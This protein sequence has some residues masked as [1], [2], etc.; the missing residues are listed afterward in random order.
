VPPLILTQF[1]L[2]VGFGAHKRHSAYFLAPLRAV[3]IH[4][5]LNREFLWMRCH[6][7]RMHSSTQVTLSPVIFSPGHFVSQSLCPQSLCPQVTF[8]PNQ[9]VPWSLCLRE[10]STFLI[11]CHT[12]M[13]T[14]SMTRSNRRP[15]ILCLQQSTEVQSNG[16]DTLEH[17]CH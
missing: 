5:A 16:H 13:F 11:F 2:W 7:Q 17:W 6:D 12:E 10:L 1:D 9:F 14:A 15:Y 4:R 3:R 8:S